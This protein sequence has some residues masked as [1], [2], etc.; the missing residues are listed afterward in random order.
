MCQS[1]RLVQP[2]RK[3]TI[4]SFKTVLYLGTKL[5]NDNAVLCNE[6][7]NEDF[8]TFKRTVYDPNLD[9][10]THDD[11]QNLWNLT[12]ALLM[13]SF[14]PAILLFSPS[15]FE[16]KFQYVFSII[17]LLMI[18]W[19]TFSDLSLNFIY[20]YIVNFSRIFKDFSVLCIYVYICIVY[21]VCTLVVY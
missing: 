1:V 18:L 5:W 17:E 19:N 9:V 7:W 2:R 8:L 3:T 11:F 12:S 4:V 14:R 20:I 21:I 15:L 16:Y 13:H 6:L 10:I